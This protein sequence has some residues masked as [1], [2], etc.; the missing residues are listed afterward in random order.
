MK[1]SQRQKGKCRGKEVQTRKRGMENAPHGPDSSRWLGIFLPSPDMPDKQEYPF[2]SR[3][4]R[5]CSLSKR[6][7]VLSLT[8][9]LGMMN[10]HAS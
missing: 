7:N 2:L 3:F 5:K 10:T 9:F 8:S 4:F 1:H 6:D